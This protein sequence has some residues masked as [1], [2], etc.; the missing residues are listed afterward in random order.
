MARCNGNC[1]NCIHPDCIISD[2]MALVLEDNDKYGNRD[3]EYAFDREAEIRA[4]YQREHAEEIRRKRLE[5]YRQRRI[6]GGK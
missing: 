5:K 4:R 3:V 1:F 6:A 2:K